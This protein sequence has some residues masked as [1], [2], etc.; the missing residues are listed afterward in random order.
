MAPGPRRVPARLAVT[1]GES[2]TSSKLIDALWPETP[3]STATQSLQNTVS[4]LRSN[5]GAEAPA[6]WCGVAGLKPSFELVPTGRFPRAA[7]HHDGRTVIGP[8]APTVALLSTALAI[9]AGPDG[10]DP[11]CHPVTIGQPRAPAH[12]HVV[13]GPVAADVAPLRRPLTGTDY[14]LTLPWS[15]TG[16]P[17]A[18][19]PA[20][21]D[22]NT[23][24]PLLPCKWRR[25][26][27]L[28]MSCSLS[29]SG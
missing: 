22:A 9:M 27:G 29:P 5:L 11:S 18:R 8:M 15:L 1:I 6:A 4:R 28:T 12:F 13:I 14:V 19:V 26:A 20:G 10:L 23:G 7:A 24:L 16:W 25:R 2:V 21:F 3:P 17:A